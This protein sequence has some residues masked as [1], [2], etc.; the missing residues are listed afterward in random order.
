MGKVIL[1]TNVYDKIYADTVILNTLVGL[2]D[3]GKIEVL[4]P[5]VVR[6][7]LEAGPFGC[8]PNDFDVTHVPDG[9]AIASL[10]VPDDCVVSDGVEYY[11]HKGNSNKSKDAII[12]HTALHFADILVT[13]DK[14]FRKRIAKV[15][16]G[17]RAMTYSD[18]C[19]YLHGL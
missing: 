19:H 8:V 10:A 2:V 15:D 1:D 5:R 11:Q 6:D 13:E 16:S 7:E 3:S 17:F 4:A 14:K 18:F 9:V 12:S